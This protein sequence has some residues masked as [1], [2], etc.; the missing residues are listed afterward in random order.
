M[1]L[2][3]E[4]S[5]A[6]FKLMPNVTYISGTD[7]FDKDGNSVKYDIDLV[8]A[9]AV[10]MQSSQESSKQASLDKL[11]ALG[12]TP[13]DLKALLG[14]NMTQAQSVAIESS[15]INSSGV[16]LTTGG[17]TGLSTV[18]TN[19]QVLTSNGTTLSW[20]TP[21]TT[22][23]GGST[24]QVQYNSSGSFAGSANMVFDGST[25]TTLNTAYTGTLTGG[26]GIVNLGSGQFYKD[27][28]GNVLIG[29]SSAPGT[30][31][32]QVIRNAN[33]SSTRLLISNSTAGSSSGAFMLFGNDTAVGGYAGLR[34]SSSTNTSFGGANAIEFFNNLANLSFS[35]A[36]SQRMNID[37]SG[38][39]GIGTSSPSA[40]FQVTQSDSN[41][42]CRFQNTA[43][44]GQS[45]DL[46]S[47][48]TGNADVG[49]NKFGIR[50]PAVSGAT[51]YRFI[52]DSSGNWKMGSTT[53]VI[54]N[55]NGRA[56][57]NQTGGVLQVVNAALTGSVSTSS[58]SMVDTG[59]T[60]TITPSS[61]SSKIL[62]LVTL[63]QISCD[64]ASLALFA[65]TRNGSTFVYNSSGGNATSYQAFA[66]GGGQSQNRQLTAGTLTYLDSP[67]STSAQTY[68]VRIANN[69]GTANSYLNQ[70]ALNTD[71]G[72]V[73]TITLMEIAQ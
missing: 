37:Y 4:Q 1:S 56:M 50:D 15:Q 19:G 64:N 3:F 66:S 68:K 69:S 32:L 59:L 71:A 22:S 13:D 20:V 41:I 47:T 33:D 25:L 27:A 43:T 44:G 72:G 45:W 63:N 54:Q 5:E 40:H 36:G 57:L 2:T 73:S 23:P 49:G 26:T 21:T 53:G 35:T 28:S 14:Q 65:V 70:W 18:G 29:T 62:V 51:G 46:L 31:Q 16:L 55:T 60:A 42:T 58:S 61:T 17:G 12:L 24:T 30:G 9:K 8:N 7:A 67:A 38:N 52:I 11:A 39:V 10:E 48:A 6:L 34:S